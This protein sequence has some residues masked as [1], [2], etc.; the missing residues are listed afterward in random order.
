MAE[1]ITPLA[2]YS[3]RTNKRDF[4]Y[5]MDT[6]E[7]D[8]MRTPKKQRIETK[9]QLVQ[10]IEEDRSKKKM[11]VTRPAFEVKKYAFADTL[12]DSTTQFKNKTELMEKYKETKEITLE[13]TLKLYS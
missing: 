4:S 11:K 10:A 7:E 9:G 8:T 6:K 5:A 13:E 3:E 2:S 1:K 12:V